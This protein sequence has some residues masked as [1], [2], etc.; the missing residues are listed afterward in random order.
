[1]CNCSRAQV[2]GMLRTLSAD[3][4]RAMLAEDEGA[5][6]TCEFCKETYLFT[7]DELKALPQLRH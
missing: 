3:E 7:V 1:M 4:I 5:E 6:V 2:A